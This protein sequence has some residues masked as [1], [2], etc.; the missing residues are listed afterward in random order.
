M[1]TRI[2]GYKPLGPFWLECDLCKEHIRKNAIGSKH[3]SG[4]RHQAALARQ[5][6]PIPPRVCPAFIVTQTSRFVCTR[7]EG[8]KGNHVGAQVGPTCTQWALRRGL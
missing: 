8:H 3:E 4:A 5:P 7:P 6:E 1:P 2:Q